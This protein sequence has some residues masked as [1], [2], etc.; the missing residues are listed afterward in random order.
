MKSMF[1][2]EQ[3]MAAYT[4]A[5]KK[6]N[7]KSE[8]KLDGKY[9]GLC[10]ILRDFLITGEE[11]HCSPSFMFGDC[12]WHFPELYNEREVFGNDV[13]A[14]WFKTWKQRRKALKNILKI[15]E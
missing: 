10:Y 9:G 7:G 5:L 11:D 2:L 15:K 6:I 8:V 13:Y 3:R 12:P 4:H 1:T 14:S